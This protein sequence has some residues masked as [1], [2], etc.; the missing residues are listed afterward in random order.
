MCR[1]TTNCPFL[2][3]YNSQLIQKEIDIY[4]T[5]WMNTFYINW[6]IKQSK[7]HISFRCKYVIQYE[8][9]ADCVFN[10][11]GVCCRIPFKRNNT[12]C[13]RAG[14]G[15]CVYLFC[16]RRAVSHVEILLLSARCYVS[17]W[18]M[19]IEFLGSERKTFVIAGGQ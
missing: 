4:E 19:Y 10:C 12:I 11:F 7:K 6:N 8:Q 1:I 15:A 14:T 5:E 3:D 17:Q 9:A 16:L 13:Y 18:R 2:F